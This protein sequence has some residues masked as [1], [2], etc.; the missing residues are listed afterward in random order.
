MGRES[1]YKDPSTKYSC[2]GLH[3]SQKLGVRLCLLES[4]EHH[5]HLLDGR[6]RIQ[7]AAHDPDAGQIFLA[8]EQLF[9]AR[10]GSL[11]VDGREKSLVAEPA[12]QMN[13]G[14]ARAFELFKDH[15]V[16]ARAGV[17]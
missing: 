12:I 15:V 1:K 6:K 10:S 16:H 7:H 2:L 4:F 9:F 13:L 11:Q 17:D 3:R 14:V 5:F 8:D